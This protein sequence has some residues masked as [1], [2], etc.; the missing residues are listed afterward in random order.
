M[1]SPPAREAHPP[2]EERLAIVSGYFNPLHVGHL[3]MMT[4]ARRLGDRLLV[5]VNNDEQQQAKSG[6][7]ICPLAD[8]MEIVAALSVVDEVVP[9]VDSDA[10]VNE[11]LAR[12]RAA[13]PARRLVFANGGDRS[14]PSAVAE[15]ETCYQLGIEVVL[16]VGGTAKADASS[17]I[18]R[19][20]GMA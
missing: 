8:R 2:G 1:Q 18:N 12:V 10:T 13:Y 6:R 3:R 4:A 14:E 5:I 17:R 16:G 15:Y 19:A 20:L 9:A 7:I 11:T